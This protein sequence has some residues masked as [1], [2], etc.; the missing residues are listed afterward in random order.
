MKRQL[1]NDDKEIIEYAAQATKL[2]SFKYDPVA[3][4][5]V[6]MEKSKKSAISNLENNPIVKEVVFDKVHN[7]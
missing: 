3:L 5:K 1:K 2:Q 7:S 4:N 6:F